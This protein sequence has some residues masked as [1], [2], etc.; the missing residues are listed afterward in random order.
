MTISLVSLIV[1]L[2]ADTAD[3]ARVNTRTCCIR[4]YQPDNLENRSGRY[5]RL[6]ENLEYGGY[7]DAD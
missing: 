3:R 2:C 5:L 4:E 6:G 1:F 7:A